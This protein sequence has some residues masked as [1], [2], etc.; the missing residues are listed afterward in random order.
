VDAA[1]RNG[2]TPVVEWLRARGGKT[3][4]ELTAGDV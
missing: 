3:A 4:D 1:A 2:A